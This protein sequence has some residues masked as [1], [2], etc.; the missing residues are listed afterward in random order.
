MSFCLLVNVRRNSNND[1]SLTQLSTDNECLLDNLR[2]VDISDSKVIKCNYQ[3]IEEIV[4]LDD[5]NIAF[6]ELNSLRNKNVN[7]IIIAQL[8]INSITHK[9][10]QLS[11]IIQGNVDV[12][13]VSETKLNETFPTDQF[14]IAGYSQPYR[15]DRNRYGGGVMIFVREDLPSKQLH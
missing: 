3:D 4:N 7:N 12:L 10:D 2:M 15:R 8:N 13:L 5:P 14:H 9:F 1:I 11:F 6:N